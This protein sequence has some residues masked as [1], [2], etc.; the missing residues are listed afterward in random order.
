MDR[1]KLKN[2]YI[3][4]FG[5]SIEYTDYLYDNVY[6]E[7]G[8]KFIEK[9]GEIISSLAILPRPFF[10]AKKTIS[11]AF[12]SAVATKKSE[13]GKGVMKE[14]MK[15][16]LN[17]F[18]TSQCAV[19][20]LSPENEAYYKSQGF[21]TILNANLVDITPK[22]PFLKLKTV[23]NS[24]EFHF[25]KMENSSKFDLVNLRSSMFSEKLFLLHKVE[26]N[27]IQK[28]YDGD[29]YLGYF[30][31]DKDGI[32]EYSLPAKYMD[33]VE[34]KSGKWFIYGS[35]K[36]FTMA[37]IINPFLLFDDLVCDKNID[38]SIKIEDD[39]LQKSYCMCLKT[40]NGRLECDRIDD[41]KKVVKIE[42]LT[43]WALGREQN[44]SLFDLSTTLK[45][46]KI[47]FTDRYL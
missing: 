11:G 13:R 31:D 20:F 2:L 3:E 9:D 6:G 32:Y 26:N 17:D 14:L 5:D 4:S 43:K 8:V 25:I 22:E 15:T 44:D 40:Q 19:I 38:C 30:I 35:G 10:Y 23:E 46:G 33:K 36:S 28:V 29:K 45:E 41:A 27:K 39:F 24:Q 1:Q 34:T 16:V 7:R 37:R 18:S 47:H 21:C 42:E 12:I